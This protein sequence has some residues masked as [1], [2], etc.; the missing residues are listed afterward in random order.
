MK[1]NILLKLGGSILLLAIFLYF[2]KVN[3][4]NNFKII[5]EKKFILLKLNNSNECFVYLKRRY[6]YI[7]TVLNK[8][9]CEKKY[10]VI[11]PRRKPKTSI[12]FDRY[13]PINSK[14]KNVQFIKVGKDIF[15]KLGEKTVFPTGN[16]IQS[17]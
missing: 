13:I 12:N 10:L 6:W 8:E 9:G 5:N 3:E 2:S 1:I 4:M 14:F 7:E 11:K 15:I 16:H 17:F